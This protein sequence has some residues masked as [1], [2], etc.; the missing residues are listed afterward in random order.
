MT[1]QGQEVPPSA[2]GGRDPRAAIKQEDGFV[3]SFLSA[4]LANAILRRLEGV[5]VTPN[6]VTIVSAAVSLVAAWGL[7]VPGFRL[8]GAVLLQLA[9]VLDCLDGQLARHRGLGSSFGAWLDQL[10]DRLR[11]IVLFGAIAVGIVAD[12]GEPVGAFLWSYAAL[13]V[14]FYR[15][16]DAMLLVRF[17]GSDYDDLHRAP[18]RTR[19][20]TD[21]VRVIDEARRRR[22]GSWGPVAQALDR[23]APKGTHEQRSGLYWLKRAL[24]FDGGERYLAI[25]L[26]AAIG[27]IDWIFPVV[28]V[29]GGL[30]YPLI[31]IR[32]WSLFGGR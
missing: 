2:G 25:S 8:F 24:L 26:L 14:V 1:S 22:E 28:V 23:L 27:R 13:V 30:V 29:W 19:D 12:G 17:L 20:A 15:H 31:T 3:A 21:K 7:A 11:D 6:Q 32:R 5:A 9:F 4:P 10:T 16:V 18:V